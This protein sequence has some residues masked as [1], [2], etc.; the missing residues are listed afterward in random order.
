MVLL[1]VQ[2]SWVED[3]G[4]A[5]VEIL[6]PSKYHVIEFFLERSKFPVTSSLLHTHTSKDGNLTKDKC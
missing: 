2:L 3:E 6:V 4:V 1:V 5:E